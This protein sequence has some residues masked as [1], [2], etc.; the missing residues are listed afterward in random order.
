MT[1]NADQLRRYEYLLERQSR[2]DADVSAHTAR[3]NTI[4]GSMNRSADALEGLRDDI[5]E[6]ADEQKRVKDELLDRQAQFR[7]EVFSQVVD[8]KLESVKH[9]TRIGMISAIACTVCT[10]AV[11]SIVGYIVVNHL[12]ASQ[13]AVPA[14]V[15][16]PAHAPELTSEAA[17]AAHSTS[18]RP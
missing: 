2:T 7:D 17:S 14:H 5:A 9:A 16:N 11:T 18:S 10:A 13:P 4:N 8:L 6:V 15:S 1:L 12:G 3:L